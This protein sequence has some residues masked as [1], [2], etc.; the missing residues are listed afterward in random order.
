M[1][2]PRIIPNETGT[3]ITMKCK[4]KAKPEPEVT[5]FRGQHKVS[6]STKIVI[7]SSKVEEDIYELTLEIKDPT[8]A[9]GG[10]YRCHV[11]NEFGESNANL[12]LNIE[13]EPEP[14]GDG[15]TFIEK[16]RIISEN[17]GKLVIMECKV[18][19][20]PKP[21]IVWTRE[22]QTLQETSRLKITMT[23]KDDIYDIKLTLAEPELTDSGLYRCNIKNDLGEL[24]ANLTLN[25]EIVPVIKDKP[26]IIKIV[27]KR[28]VIIECIVC[29][30][31]EP[32]CTW[33][34][35]ESAIKTSTRHQV[36]IEQV[37]EGEYA[38]KLEIAEV[39]ETD[40]GS[41]KLIAKND[42]GEATSQVVELLEI[43][44]DDSKK[45]KPVISKKLTDQT[46]EEGRSF[47]LIISLKETDRTV[48]VMWYKNTTVIKE[49]S[50]ISTSF[51]GS[52]ARLSISKSREEHTSTYKVVVSNELGQDESASKI[53]V[54]KKEDDKKKKEEEEKKKKELE[55]KK[56]KEEEA[57][58]KKAAEEEKKKAEQIKK[59]V[60]VGPFLVELRPAS[61]IKRPIEVFFESNSA[62][63]MFNV[64]V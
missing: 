20:N 12:N 49:S 38:V 45:T 32:K 30:K 24:N 29:S 13:A 14:E 16:P 28:T 27:K 54:K 58:K 52:I 19:A 57:A 44:V 31:F 18:K 2:K 34:K 61:P 6:E 46:I 7:K 4:C 26:K 21:T 51:D 59:E 64:V 3:L 62:I 53:T 43:P 42:K 36:N 50:E 11:K 48:K 10:T 39:K 15:P 35:E 5:W 55:E 41:Y 37:K 8:S 1:E 9:D 63:V 33:Y 40:K 25:I 56:K 23:N 17:N 47:D 60:K 22:G